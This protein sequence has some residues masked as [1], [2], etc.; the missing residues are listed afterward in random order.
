MAPGLVIE[1]RT[2]PPSPVAY[3]LMP[4]A[5]TKAFACTVDAAPNARAETFNAPP[6]ETTAVDPAN[7]ATPTANAEAVTLPDPLAEAD[8]IAVASTL[9]VPRLVTAALVA[10]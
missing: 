8:E 5:T 10:D 2:S 4:V 9:M 1:A 3:W 7:W 6:F